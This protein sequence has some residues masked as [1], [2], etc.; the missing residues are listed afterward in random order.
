MS[1]IGKQPIQ[2]PDKV[3]VT[4]EQGGRFAG[5]IV[6]VKGPK[7]ELQLDLRKGIAVEVKDKEVQ[8]TR[9]KNTRK[10]KEQYGLYRSM[11]ANMIDGVVEGYSKELQLVG[12]GYKAFVK[13]ADLELTLGLNHPVLVPGEEGINYE[14][15]EETKITVS[16][17]DK[18]RVGQ[19]A[20]RIKRLKKPD[21]YKGKGIYYVG[22]RIRRKPGKAAKAEAAA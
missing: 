7:G 21:P 9:E 16:G 1:R 6:T 3:E 15:A 19:V 20:A 2:I 13:G 12:V 22:E 5:F 18:V 4:A 17:I 8:L 11:I 10:A 14:V